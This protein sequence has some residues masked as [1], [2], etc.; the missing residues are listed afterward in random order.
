VAAPDVAAPDVAAPDVAAPD[1]A[2]PDVAAPDVAA[3]DVAAPDVAAPDVA[4]PDVAAPD[5][6]APGTSGGASALERVP[7][8]VGGRDSLTATRDVVLPATGVNGSTVVWQSGDA[9]VISASGAVTRPAAGRRDAR[10]TLTAT[11]THGT[12]QARKTFTVTV[13]AEYDDRQAVRHA[14]GEL[15]VHGLPEVRENL[16]LPALGAW[17]TTVSWASSRPAVIAPNGDVTRG[18]SAVRVTL[19]ATVSRGAAKTTRAFAATVPARPEVE[20][21]KGY[22]FSYFTGE[23][24]ATGEQVYF[25]LSQG[26]DPLH[27]QQ[28]NN[29]NPVLTSSL[30]ETGL[31][32][33]FIIRSPQ[34]DKFYQI[35]T[36]LKIYGNG[37]WDA[38]QRTGSKSIMVWESTD[39]VHWTDQR[40]V[41]VSPDTAGNT[42][43]PEAFYDPTIGAYVVFWASKLYAATD[44]AHAGSSYNRM[45]YATTRDFWTFSEPKVWKDPGYSVIDST[46]I[47]HNG[48]YYR[49]TK[50]ERDQSSSSPCSKFIIAEKSARIRDADYDFVAE[51]I[52]QNA[53]SR[54]EGPLIFKDNDAEKW[55]LF[56]DEFGG[57]GY[58]PLESTDLDSGRWTPSTDYAL[59][60]RPRHGTVLPVTRAEYDR[61]LTAYQ[62]DQALTR[63]DP[64]K[65]WTRT[66]APPALP[67]TVV[68]HYADGSTRETAVTW[69]AIDPASYA[70]PG[71]FTVGGTNG[72]RATVVATS[73]EIP[74]ERVL[75]APAAV[76]TAPGVSRAL[77]AEVQPSNADNP[78]LTWRS[79][80]PAVATVSATGR[81]TTLVPGRTTVTAVA[82]GGRS[83][84]VRVEVTEAVPRDLLLHYAFEGDASDSS[85]RG[86]DGVV[87][88]AASWSDGGIK[89]SGGAAVTIPGGLLRDRSSVTV[90]ARVRWN[91]TASVNQWIY[92]LGVDSN[93]YLF[94]TPANGGKLLYSAITTGSWSAE[95]KLSGAS[96]LPGGSR[97]H[98]AVT[99]DGATGTAAMYLNGVAVAEAGG[100]TV[101]PSD[102]DD[103]TKNY[104][105]YIGKSFYAA[106]PAFD[107]TVDDFRVY[108]RALTP[109]EILEES[110]NTT[111]IVAVTAAGLKAP[112]VITDGASRIVLPLAP[113][114]D[115]RTVAPAFTLAAGARVSPPGGTV[116]DLREPVTYTVTGADGTERR[117]TVEAHVMRSPLP[118]GLNADP[119]IAVFDGV[120]WIYPTTDGFDGWSG[121]RFHAFS[122][123]D[124]VNWTDHGVILDLGPDVGWAD[125]R[126]WAPAV[127][128]KDGKYY[129]YFCADGNIGVAVADDP[130]GPFTDVLGKPL[131]AAGSFAG[132][133]IDPA[134]FT[135]DDGVTYLYWGNGHAYVVPLNADL[136]SFDKSRVKEIT[137]AGYNEGSFVVKRNG[138]YYFMWSQND[139]RDPD[140]QVAYATGASPSGPF[141]PH[142]LILT[143]RPE[144]GI[145][146]TGHHSVVRAPGT[147]E[148]FI[149][150]HR[151][152][153]PGGDGTHRETTIDR[154][155]F[156]AD[157]LIEPVEP[158]LEGP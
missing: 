35:A 79:S 132:Q 138:T 9:S 115:P 27:W 76:R 157:G 129:F 32:D 112:A 10:V 61:L 45:M 94:S 60:G 8:G 98:V 81:L 25:S 68:A 64:V 158:T 11:L 36:D 37:N 3:P 109:A 43:A 74:V 136:T 122:S 77:T 118:A 82:R 117:W 150:Y 124:L 12:E 50:D 108:G 70:K 57:R 87:S 143:R 135:D 93:R 114:T 55:H 56:I 23:G 125:S 1:V 144:L 65:V 120:Y 28:L 21:K 92:G 121:T 134:A 152:A 83:G 126:A 151:F 116:R 15:V 13:P 7:G 153:V 58:V 105:G 141:T 17:G 31:R 46:M 14:A 110:G 131:I 34:G 30:G 59:P 41:K 54:G 140:Y 96:A 40:L 111:G 2:A 85:G 29:S 18:S 107:G 97:Q 113:G 149:A 148:W 123:P 44:T 53:M 130:A 119:N 106:D 128:E 155:R 75:A 104:S 42:W 127:A 6:A 52:G 48:T 51:C 147:D 73:G 90:E 16:N 133:M 99:L 69:N 146:G 22:L 78:A 139:T 63:V 145:V 88:G 39:L 26:N 33:P 49:F 47:E 67:A 66:G 156:T 84:T 19:T 86:F 80:N 154:L 71:A 62:P 20:A 24:T 89:L 38:A 142:G 102:L 72:A 95:S 4:A 103:A 101:K 137:P 100:V 91:G 5:V